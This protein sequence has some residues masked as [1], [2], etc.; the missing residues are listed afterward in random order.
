ML[1]RDCNLRPCQVVRELRNLQVA[2]FER[3]ASVLEAGHVSVPQT[4]PIHLQRVL[5]GRGGGGVGSPPAHVVALG[6]ID[7]VGSVPIGRAPIMPVSKESFGEEAVCSGAYA[8]RGMG[9]RM[10][11]P[12][13]RM[14]VLASREHLCA[15]AAVR[16]QADRCVCVHV[17]ALGLLIQFTCVTPAR[18]QQSGLTANRCCMCPGRLPL[19]PWL[20]PPVS[21]HC[22]YSRDDKCRALLAD[23]SG[24]GCKF[25]ARSNL[26][27]VRAWTLC[28]RCAPVV[29]LT[30]V[31]L[32]R[33]CE[34]LRVPGLAPLSHLGRCCRAHSS[35][36][37]CGSGW[38]MTWR[39]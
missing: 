22:L 24:P 39:T 9:D 37:R 19:P 35:R 27:V 8:Q 3:P 6:S 17:V 29:P 30:L 34:S 16:S 12:F 26:V 15:N 38:C 10:T 2:Y 5:M 11:D 14:G 36:T 28:A 23:R 32:L 21:A 25:R 1:A 20:P 4:G 7:A 18:P 33:V 13:L 31:T